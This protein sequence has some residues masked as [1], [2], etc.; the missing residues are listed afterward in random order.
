MK[1]HL[2]TE[3]R[4]AIAWAAAEEGQRGKPKLTE[5]VLRAIGAPLPIGRHR[6]DT[7]R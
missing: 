1:L 4:E 6:K 5:Y 3:L 2:P 7:M